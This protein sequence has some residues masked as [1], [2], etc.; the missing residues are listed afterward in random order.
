MAFI[1]LFTS[2]LTVLTNYLCAL[3]TTLTILITWY[4]FHLMNYIKF[5][6]LSEINKWSPLL[7]FE[8]GTTPVASRGDNH[9][10]MT[11]WLVPV[12]VRHQNAQ[13]FFFV[14]HTSGYQTEWSSSQMP[15]WHA[16]GRTS[17]MTFYNLNTIGIQLILV[18]LTSSNWIRT[19]LFGRQMLSRY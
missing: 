2:Q 4:K 11:T 15:F 13:P 10:A 9:W 14:F 8:P 5:P 18:I 19:V 6:F 17:H 1:L 7:G 16:N 12:F 3:D